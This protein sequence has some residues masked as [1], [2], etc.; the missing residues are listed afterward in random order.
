MKTAAPVLVAA[1]NQTRKVIVLVVPREY[2]QDNQ[3]M[4]PGS[5]IPSMMECRQ[6]HRS[7][8]DKHLLHCRGPDYFPPYFIT[9]YKL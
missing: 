5:T 3:L 6:L 1:V 7:R 9:Y 2:F 4:G 8:L